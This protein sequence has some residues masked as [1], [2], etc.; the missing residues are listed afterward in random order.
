[1]RARHKRVRKVQ[2]NKVCFPWDR[3]GRWR[4]TNSANTLTNW[5]K[6]PTWNTP[7]SSR[8]VLPSVCL[9][10]PL[11]WSFLVLFMNNDDDDSFICNLFRSKVPVFRFSNGF[12][13]RIFKTKA[14]DLR[15][16]SHS[17]WS[18]RPRRNPRPCKS[19]SRPKPK[20]FW[21]SRPMPRFLIR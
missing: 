13:A 4:L 1:M 19:P 14:S 17:Q 3:P 18:S 9:S 7:P 15:N 8:S 11:L 12:K 10:K 20:M 6:T 16:Q 21:K 2:R 5:R